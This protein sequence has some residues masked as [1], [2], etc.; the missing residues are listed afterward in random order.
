MTTDRLRRDYRLCLLDLSPRDRRTAQQLHKVVIGPRLESIIGAFYERLETINE[1][2]AIM[3]DGHDRA[4]LRHAQSNYLRTLGVN[5]DTE[6]YF[7]GRI[8]VGLAH[9]RVGVPLSLYLCAFRFLQQ[10]LLKN[11]RAA[12]GDADEQHRLADF[13]IKITAL[14]LSLAVDAYHGARVTS[15]EASIAHLDAEERLQRQRAETDALTGVANREYTLN[16]LNRALRQDG[17]ASTSLCLAIADLDHFKRINDLYGHLSG[18]A[19][20]RDVVAR[21]RA[22]FRDFDLIGRYGGEEFA[23]M[24]TG[25]RLPLA[26]EIC[27]RVRRRVADSPVAVGSLSIPVTISFGVA[28]ARPGDDAESLFERADR[29]LYAAKQAGRDRVGSDS[30]VTGR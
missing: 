24:L 17:A 7:E 10:L 12:V 13:V 29:A 25:A 4:A 9:E 18:D 3:E 19:V 2:Q 27:E 11:I 28:E 30:D 14:D 23:I 21:L 16:A 1:F 22:G 6:G 8:R 15:L 26:L 5:F 20:L